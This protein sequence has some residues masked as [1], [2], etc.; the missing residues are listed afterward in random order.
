MMS[1]AS[2]LF[3]SALFSHS[4]TAA[5]SSV[6]PP[7]PADVMMNEEAGRG[8]LLIVTVRTESG[9][10]WPL[11]MDTGCAKTGFDP[12]LVPKLGPSN[13]TETFWNF[14]VGHEGALYAPPKLYLGGVLL[15]TS[16]TNVGTYD[17]GGISAFVGR[18]IMGILGIDVL[19][20][21]CVQLDFNARRIRFL[22][23]EHKGD[24][25]KAF[26][27]NEMSDGCFYMEANLAHVAGR[28]TL[29]DTGSL[30]DGW[31]R[32]DIFDTWTNLSKP[33]HSG[34][35]RYPKGVLGGETYPEL[36]LERL[37]E[38][39]LSSGDLHTGYNGIG[40]Q[41]LSL[42]LV[43]FD[44]PER[45]MYLKRTMETSG[46]T[47]AVRF[48]K[49]LK[50]NGRLP[51][52]SKDDGM[53]PRQTLLHFHYPDSAA[54]EAHKVGDSLFIYHYVIVRASEGSEWKLQK[55]WRTDGSTNQ[56]YSVP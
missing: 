6:Q 4:V 52:W 1:C 33:P 38:N 7:R 46:Y 54:F 27:L 15:Q 18:P 16:G 19:K 49:S 39:T 37:D 36:D 17:C 12:S 50:E 2:G 34:Q 11:V 44:F 29:I 25:G 8:G 45:T 47:S 56:E 20:N 26:S 24:W 30:H 43:T 32:P 41:F 51:G 35:S 48:L 23:D 10:E 31:L 14:G 21:Y 9:D 3:L 28:G 42:H 22:D 5:E 53:L 55:A 13:A 40:I